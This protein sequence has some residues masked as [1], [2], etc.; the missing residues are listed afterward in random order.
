MT[1]FA[2]VLVS[3]LAALLVAVFAR[4]AGGRNDRWGI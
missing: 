2:V 3:L 1:Y 4:S